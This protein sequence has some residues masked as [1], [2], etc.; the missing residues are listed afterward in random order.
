MLCFFCLI[1]CGLICPFCSDDHPV[2]ASVPSSEDCFMRRCAFMCHKVIIFTGLLVGKKKT[3]QKT[4]TCPFLLTCRGLFCVLF[5]SL[6]SPL[7]AKGLLQDPR[8]HSVA[9]RDCRPP[10]HCLLR[11]PRSVA[12][13]GT[14]KKTHIAT[15][16]KNPCIFT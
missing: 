4:Y 11:M 7:C 16:K 12:K 9:P 6:G 15:F 1:V 14:Q 10:L 8:Q 13:D 2:R 5:L 3:K